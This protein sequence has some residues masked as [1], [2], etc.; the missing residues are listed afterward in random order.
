MLG[1][2]ERSTARVGLQPWCWGIGRGKRAGTEPWETCLKDLGPAPWLWLCLG[3]GWVPPG[4]RSLSTATSP[5]RAS[6]VKAGGGTSNTRA[7]PCYSLSIPGGGGRLLWM[8]I[9]VSH[10]QG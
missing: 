4:P 1:E 10:L 6:L 2:Q 3:Y 5:V 9:T 8:Q 7:G